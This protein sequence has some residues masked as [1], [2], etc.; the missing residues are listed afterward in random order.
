MTVA[1]S[2][3][4]DLDAQEKLFWS[5]AGPVKREP[6]T[7]QTPLKATEVAKRQR[8]GPQ[9]KGKSKGKGSK[10]KGKGF[11]RPG[12]PSSGGMAVANDWMEGYTNGSGGQLTSP[13]N[14]QQDDMIPATDHEWLTHRGNTLSQLVLRQEQVIAS[15]RQDTVVYLFIRS[16]QEGMIPV[17][18]EAADKWRKMKDV[19]LIASETQRDLQGQRG[20]DQGGEAEL[21]GRPKAL[22][23]SHLEPGT[24]EIGGG[25][26]SPTDVDGGLA[27][28]ASTNAESRQ[29][30]DSTEVQVGASTYDGSHGGVDSVSDLHLTETRG[31]ALVE[32]IES[33]DRSGLLAHAGLSSTPGSASLRQSN[34]A[35]LESDVS[36]I[37]S[38]KAL[39]QLVLHNPTNLC[40]LHSTIM[41]VHWVMLQVRLHD[42]RAPLPPQVF[43]DGHE[44]MLGG[45]ALA[46][47]MK[48]NAASHLAAVNRTVLFVNS[49]ELLRALLALTEEENYPLVFGCVA[50]KDRTGLLS[51]L[52]LSALG[53]DR[54]TI[55][56]DYLK[57]NE[58]ARHIDACNQVAQHLWWRQLAAESPERWQRMQATLPTLRFDATWPGLDGS[59][60]PPAETSPAETADATRESQSE[61]E[62]LA[63][64]QGSV[65]YLGT[66]KYTL[67]LLDSEG[68]ALAYLD[69]I[70]FGGPELEKLL[71][72]LTAIWPQMSGMVQVPAGSAPFGAVVAV[73]N[74]PAPMGARPYRTIVA[75]PAPSPAPSSA[76]M[77]GSVRSV[78]SSP[79]PAA[80]PGHGGA[81]QKSQAKAVPH[82]HPAHP[83][84]VRSRVGMETPG[85]RSS[86]AA[87]RTSSVDSGVSHFRTPS[88]DSDFRESRFYSGQRSPS[89][90]SSASLQKVQ[91]NLHQSRQ[92]MQE[93][94]QTMQAMRGALESSKE[95]LTRSSLVHGDDVLSMSAANEKEPTSLEELTRRLQSQQEALIAK[96]TQ[97]WEQRFAAL[98]QALSSGLEVATAATGSMN[99]RL[100]RFVSLAEVL[101]GAVER[102][103]HSSKDIATLS[104]KVSQ[105]EDDVACLAQELASDQKGRSEAVTL[106][107]VDAAC[108]ELRRELGAFVLLFR[109]QSEAKARLLRSFAS[110]QQLARH[111]GS[112]PELLGALE[113]LPEASRSSFGSDGGLKQALG[114]LARRLPRDAGEQVPWEP[115]WTPRLAA[116]LNQ[117]GAQGANLR[118]INGLSNALLQA[119]GNG[120]ESLKRELPICSSDE[121][122]GLASNVRPAQMCQGFANDYV[123]A[124]LLEEL[125]ER[126]SAGALPLSEL[127][128][129]LQGLAMAREPGPGLP[130][131]PG[132]VSLGPGT[133]ACLHAGL[134]NSGV[135][136]LSTP[137]LLQLIQ[138]SV[139]GQGG[140]LAELIADLPS[141]VQRMSLPELAAA[142][143]A[144][145][146]GDV[147]WV[148]LE[149]LT[150][151]DLD[152]ESFELALAVACVLKFPPFEKHRQILEQLESAAAS[153]SPSLQARLL[154]LALREAST[155]DKEQEEKDTSVVNRILTDVGGRLAAADLGGIPW[156]HAAELLQALARSSAQA[157]PGLVGGLVEVIFAGDMFDR[158]LD[159][160]ATVFFAL[161][162]LGADLDNLA[163]RCDL[164]AKLAS[165]EKQKLEAEA[166]IRLFWAM[167]IGKVQDPVAWQLCAARVTDA[168]SASDLPELLAQLRSEAEEARHQLLQ[169]LEAKPKAAGQARAALVTRPAAGWRH[170]EG[171][172]LT[173]L[174]VGRIVSGKVT[175]C[176]RDMV[177]VD[178]M[179]EQDGCFRAPKGQFRVGETLRNLAIRAVDL[180]KGYVHLSAPKPKPAKPSAP[181]GKDG[182]AAAGQVWTALSTKPTS[183]WQHKE[184]QPLAEL[185]VGRVVSGKVT[186]C[187]LNRVWVDIGAE[188]DGCFRTGE[189]RFQVG[190]VLQNLTIRAVDLDKALGDLSLRSDHSVLAPRA[191]CTSPH[192][193]ELTAAKKSRLESPSACRRPVLNVLEGEG[194]GFN[195]SVSS[196]TTSLS[197]LS[198]ALGEERTER[199]R[200]SA[201]QRR[202]AKQAE[203]LESRL[204]T[205]TEQL[206]QV[207]R[208]QQ[209]AG[210]SSPGAGTSGRL[211]LLAGRSRRVSGSGSRSLGSRLIG[212]IEEEEEDEEGNKAKAKGTAAQ[213][214]QRRSLKG[215]EASEASAAP[216]Q[217]DG[218]IFSRILGR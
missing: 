128:P 192:R 141:R 49:D 212:P 168:A 12:P 85:D 133:L 116:V 179:A 211:A 150:R 50:G 169:E 108:E 136:S 180:E 54:E 118:L 183:G 215:W 96:L 17:L 181:K 214:A 119:A 97:R 53:C 189:R 88:R 196:G 148:R 217:S 57:T 194:S 29:R 42:A 135:K 76:P 87:S 14:T 213:M 24:A 89:V 153:A 110:A 102:V 122:L 60:R 35:N 86:K 138:S 39:L 206:A 202:V 36:V 173:E 187:F 78:A 10:G 204:Q 137:Q 149:E 188:R 80:P 167:A 6:E 144:L 21:G 3:S 207:A 79:A 154:L 176:Y 105:I 103:I 52:I 104:R 92:H 195:G 111:L 95:L 132:L 112:P 143:P 69:S 43:T 40:Y 164:A 182:K 106:A 190:E 175:N 129:L 107:E 99:D 73:G 51:C 147:A 166:L 25:Q 47:D 178:I 91:T 145:S 124:V 160:L 55:V 200:L 117:L 28:S 203:Q 120:I 113:Q 83:G 155:S 59:E 139:S 48:I 7:A 63:V 205:A 170:K 165:G 121:N 13:W 186:N 127:L 197:S 218:G 34:P 58:A 4:M 16:G 26:H 101:E 209:E 142:A 2:D 45:F 140:P 84:T 191:S 31:R 199:L 125:E 100:T 193:A 93:V 41:A 208:A 1:S 46:K 37:P 109:L 70:G 68:G 18:C 38:L 32:H 146:T 151:V 134:A 177:F 216:E 98:E 172:P 157:P 33:M 62:A 30:G 56:H 15:M 5:Q 131:L 64:L 163:T 171:R 162:E 27:G 159:E 123:V 126:C 20:N 130:G 77:S 67:D 66:L 114:E 94:E 115:A 74:S 19:N 158:T 156:A 185:E 44:R 90:E 210:T 81:M 8:L 11:S 198:A 75:G 184:G 23:A 174:K 161:A 72:I 201:E 9:D 71:G 65:A 22:E 61:S 82:A 152:S